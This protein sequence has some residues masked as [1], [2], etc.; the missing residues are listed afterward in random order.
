MKVLVTGASGFLGR[1]VVPAVAAAGHEVIALVR[2]TAAID[3]LAWPNSIAIL[4]GDLRQL[5]DWSTQLGDVEA[6]VHLAAASS[7]D[8]PTQFSGTVA[9]TEKFLDHLPMRS[10]RRFVHVSSFS[11]YDYSA[12]GFRG[13]RESI[14]GGDRDGQPRGFHR[15]AQPLELAD[16][17]DGIVAADPN[18]AN[19]AATQQPEP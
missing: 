18:S 11:V 14:G 12:V 10:L 13:V 7:G 5:G 8:L 15:P 17:G 2:P 6:V 1:A 9:A 16:S 3:S 19:V 4:R